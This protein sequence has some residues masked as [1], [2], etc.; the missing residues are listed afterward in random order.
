MAPTTR[1]AARKATG[2][3]SSPPNAPASALATSHAPVRLDSTTTGPF[4]TVDDDPNMIMDLDGLK[5]VVKDEEDLKLL[6]QVLEDVP[7]A[8]IDV[9]EWLEQYKRDQ[10]ENERKESGA[11]VK[12]VNKTGETPAA[13]DKTDPSTL[14]VN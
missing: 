1:S 8:D 6:K 10:A 14:E 13:A 9:K 12:E 5:N 11:S 3:V 2:I 7:A 4:R